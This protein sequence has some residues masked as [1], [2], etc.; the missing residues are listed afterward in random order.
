M[1]LFADCTTLSSNSISNYIEAGL[2]EGLEVK[3]SIGE[4]RQLTAMILHH[5][6]SETL[7][8][9]ADLESLHLQAGHS[10]TTARMT[11]GH[12]SQSDTFTVSK[13]TIDQYYHASHR[14]QQFL[15]QTPTKRVLEVDHQIISQESSIIPASPGNIFTQTSFRPKELL[16][17]LKLHL[18]V[19]KASFTCQEQYQSLLAILEGYSIISVLPTGFGKSLL[20][21]LIPVIEKSYTTVVVPMFHSLKVDLVSRCIAKKISVIDRVVDI[22]AL[23]EPIPRLFIL[24]IN[25][26]VTS[27]GIYLMQHLNSSGALKRIVIDEAQEFVYSTH[28]RDNIMKLKLLLIQWPIQIV[29]L[30]AT[31]PPKY[32]EFIS[33]FFNREF[34]LIRRSTN[35]SN[36]SYNFNVDSHSDCTTSTC[37]KKLVD[38]CRQHLSLSAASQ[39]RAIIYCSK[40]REV[41]IVVEL[42][43]EYKVHYYYGGAST[44][45]I[46]YDEW[47]SHGYIMVAT[48]AFGQGI[49]YQH[50]RNVFVLGSV[51]KIIDLSQMA[52]R[53]GRDGRQSYFYYYTCKRRIDSMAPTIYPDAQNDQ[54]AV[55]ANDLKRFLLSQDCYRYNLLLEV[56]GAGVRCFE[57]P[58]NQFCSN[59]NTSYSCLI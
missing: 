5:Y 44:N 46:Q 36:I 32:C 59:C 33:Q 42:L 9:D 11:Y 26:I 24:D 53:S 2:C 7:E 12:N 10:G 20:P 35:R 19:P 27:N 3:T 54:E 34:S 55:N 49:D 41:N 40:R 48:T 31:L 57:S 21:L 8:P 1:Y 45:D 29:L 28:Y 38:L 39:E 13:L 15:L 16:D 23:Q 51:Y 18:N 52:G 22:S 4:Y 25:E 50:I 6:F 17:A 37:M 47:K 56:D 14:W 58:E 43:R 30:S